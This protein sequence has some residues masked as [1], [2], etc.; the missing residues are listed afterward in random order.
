MLLGVPFLPFCLYREKMKE[1][2]KMRRGGRKEDPQPEDDVIMGLYQVALSWA[3]PSPSHNVPTPLSALPSSGVVQPHRCH[4]QVCPLLRG[5]S[6]G[7]LCLPSSGT[8]PHSAP[9]CAE[10]LPNP[11]CTST[12]KRLRCC[13]SQPWPGVV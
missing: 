3:L 8:S 5:S 1:V 7:S 4:A 13:A 12:G 11:N 9:S 10:G 2:V 6:P